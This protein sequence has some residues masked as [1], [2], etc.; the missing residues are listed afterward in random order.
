VR[1][2]STQLIILGMVVAVLA[3][4]L[5]LAGCVSSAPRTQPHSIVLLSVVMKARAATD[6]QPTGIMIGVDEQQGAAGQQFAF[7]SNTRIPGQYTIFLVRLDLAPGKHRLT[8]LAAVT[9]AGV[10]APELDISVD[11]PFELKA[12]TTNYLGHLEWNYGGSRTSA[13][14]LV[15]A[16][17]YENDLPELVHAWP[18]LR[19]RSV[20]RRA[21]PRITPIRAA[22]RDPGS[23][24]VARVAS[25]E[26]GEQQ[27]V[28][29]L[30][31][32]VAANL[33]RQAQV[34]FGVFLTKAYPRAFA[35]ATSGEVGMA[36]GG[37]GVIQRALDNCRAKSTP[38]SMP[39]CRLFAVDDTVLPQSDEVA[40]THSRSRGML[41]MAR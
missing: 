6:Q 10:G 2:D 33:P 24:Q 12:R 19:R 34:A 35:V 37:S 1:H 5:P 18:A 36:A 21:P 26:H 13:N 4:V 16:D 29:P 22:S 15:L 31:A 41:L 30:D 11:L 23:A 27:A 9:G 20:V 3:A 39:A 40:R 28:A 17:A 7:P 32:S 14:D 8:R 38:T 25:H